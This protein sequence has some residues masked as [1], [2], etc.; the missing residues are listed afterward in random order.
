[1]CPARRCRRA[2]PR[3]RVTAARPVSSPFPIVSP[4]EL[5]SR[6]H[7]ACPGCR[8]RGR[9]PCRRVPAGL[10]VRGRGD[11]AAGGRGIGARPRQGGGGRG[12]GRGGR[13]P[14]GGGRAGG[15]R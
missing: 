15:G 8:W 7:I 2:T 9:R 1:S 14:G 6:V 12:A 10:P 11:R 3:L 5:S 13:G 4:H